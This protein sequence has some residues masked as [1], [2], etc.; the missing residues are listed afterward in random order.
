VPRQEKYDLEP[1]DDDD[2]EEDV[3]PS[4]RARGGYQ[5]GGELQRKLAQLELDVDR[6]QGWIRGGSKTDADEAAMRRQRIKSQEAEIASLKRQ[7]GGGGFGFGGRTGGGAGTH[8]V[9]SE[10]LCPI[11]Q[12]IMHD[13]VTAG[14][15]YT[16][17]RGPIENWLG[18]HNTSPMTGGKMPN[19]P[20]QANH[21][22]KSSIRQWQS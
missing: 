20:L 14:D 2:Y 7:L 15:G 16:Y 17:E 6:E 10:Y 13:P 21:A 11:T 5:D 3:K 8:G 18:S 22:L 12:E 4:G 1:Y 19:A 9:P